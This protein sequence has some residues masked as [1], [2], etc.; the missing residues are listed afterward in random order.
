M[1][2]ATRLESRPSTHQRLDAFRPNARL[3]QCSHRHLI[4][5]V[6][7]DVLQGAAPEGSTHSRWL[8]ELWLCTAHE[9]GRQG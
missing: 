2:T 9:L 1:H 8:S 4:A 6:E 5:S 3:G 7:V